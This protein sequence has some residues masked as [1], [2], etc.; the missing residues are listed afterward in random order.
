ME[1]E[2]LQSPPRLSVWLRTKK[3]QIKV[4]EEPYRSDEGVGS[5]FLSLITIKILKNAWRNAE[6]NAGCLL[7]IQIQQI[8]KN[9]E[10]GGGA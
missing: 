3:G 1:G 4:E 8:P 6:F 7:N 10:G 5:G 2:S 9:S